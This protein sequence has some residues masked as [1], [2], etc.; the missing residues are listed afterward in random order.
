M[1][2]VLEICGL[3]KSFTL[4]NQGGI[5]LPVLDGVD[6]AIYPGECVALNGRSGSGKS[7]LLRTLQGNYRVG[8]GHVWVR[9]SD[10]S[11]I[12]LATA[13]PRQVIE[14]RRSTIGYV[15]QFLHVVPRVPAIEIVAEPVRARGADPATARARAAALLTRLN[16]PERLWPL[17]PATFSGGEQQRVNIARGFAVEYPILLLDEPTASLD[18][19][20][21]AAVIGLID[22]ALGHGTAIV[23]IFHDAEV[24]DRVAGRLYTMTEA[25]A[26]A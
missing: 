21:R 22:E 26:A 11:R 24:R 20:N 15:S 5:T 9:R 13:S 25:R 14:L 2:P 3:A 16:V 18:G 6:L 23:G 4:H 12:D 8:S 17:A 7:T 10:G 19:E 1:E